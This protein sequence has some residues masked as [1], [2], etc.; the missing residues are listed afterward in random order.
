[1]L[2]A[3]SILSRSRG[4]ALRITIAHLTI[5][6]TRA[7]KIRT[8]R[9]MAA[10]KTGECTKELYFSGWTG[11]VWVGTA[12][13]WA[14]CVVEVEASCG[15]AEFDAELVAA[16]KILVL[17]LVAAGVPVG[18]WDV[19]ESPDVECAESDPRLELIVFEDVCNVVDSCAED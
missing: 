7:M 12:M 1:M 8:P 2:G 17:V 18:V 19:S 14:V 6:D 5:K 11:P 10:A 15:E 16:A 3:T 13:A 9:T 4:L